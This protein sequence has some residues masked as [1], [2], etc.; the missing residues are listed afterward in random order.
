MYIGKHEHIR[1]HQPKVYKSNT[2]TSNITER[3]IEII[4]LAGELGISRS[5]L[6]DE[7]LLGA[8]RHTLRDLIRR[9]RLKG[10]I[11]ERDGLIYYLTP[12]EKNGGSTR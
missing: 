10:L 4:K 12:G 3:A 9:L 11:E 8:R 1:I 7:L 6:S 2:G 5:E